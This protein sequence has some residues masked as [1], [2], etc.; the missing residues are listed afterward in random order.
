[1]LQE[2]YNP[3]TQSL[4]MFLDNMTSVTLQSALGKTMQIFLAKLNVV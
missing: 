1:M 2:Q 4:N 3:Q